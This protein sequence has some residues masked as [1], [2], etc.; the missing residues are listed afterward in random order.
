MTNPKDAHNIRGA[1]F[2]HSR[3]F[4]P[5]Y[6]V[7]NKTIRHMLHNSVQTANQN[8]SRQQRLMNGFG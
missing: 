4:D 1:M 2:G 8:A 6:R 3:H 7:G 5:W